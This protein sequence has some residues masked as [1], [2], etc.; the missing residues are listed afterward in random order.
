[1]IFM[2]PRGERSYPVH[3]HLMMQTKA[4]EI[5]HFDCTGEQY[6]CPSADWLTAPREFTK[7]MADM[8]EETEDGASNYKLERP[9]LDEQYQGYWGQIFVNFDKLFNQLG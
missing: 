3:P 7:R 4:R 9:C 6:E 1:M 8:L 5:L 2:Y